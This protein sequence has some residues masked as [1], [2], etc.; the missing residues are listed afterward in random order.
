M[1]S[2]HDRRLENI[3][4]RMERLA[5]QIVAQERLVSDARYAAKLAEYIV[6]GLVGIIAIGVIGAM[7]R[8]V[9]Q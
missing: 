4:L 6:F 5:R 7:L 3:E 2:E 8:L 1:T 9:V